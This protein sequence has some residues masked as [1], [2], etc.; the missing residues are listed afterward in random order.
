[1]RRGGF[2][3]DR[4]LTRADGRGGDGF[5]G[6]G[7]GAVRHGGGLRRRLGRSG[8]GAVRGLGLACGFGSQ[9][10][11]EGDDV[12]DGQVCRR[13]EA[14]GFGLGECAEGLDLLVA[15]VAELGEG[16]VGLADGVTGLTEP[17]EAVVVRL[18]VHQMLPSAEV[19]RMS[20]VT[21]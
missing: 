3:S 21:V 1:M 15:L 2:L 12:L 20:M 14:L 16:L 19:L 10:R 11:Y 13:R 17:G 5:E 18:G 9:M 8:L 6:R 7:R 4:L